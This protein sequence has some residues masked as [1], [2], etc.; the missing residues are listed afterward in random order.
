M[1]EKTFAINELFAKARLSDPLKT[2]KESV[3]T[4]GNLVEL[5]TQAIARRTDTIL[6]SIEQI[7]QRQKEQEDKISGELKR[8]EKHQDESEER[9]KWYPPFP[10]M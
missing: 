7:E 10:E 6:K 8:V 5:G 1:V 3:D 4:I 9:L 2:Y